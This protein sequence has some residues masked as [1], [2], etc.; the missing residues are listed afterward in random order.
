MVKFNVL[1]L[2]LFRLLGNKRDEK[3]ANLVLQ[4]CQIQVFQEEYQIKKMITHV[5]P[6]YFEHLL[7]LPWVP[8]TNQNKFVTQTIP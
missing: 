6:D 4:Q 7:S 5:Y 8:S 2:L 3:K 1:K